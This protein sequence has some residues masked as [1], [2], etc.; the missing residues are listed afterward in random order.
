MTW[1]REDLA[2]KNIFYDEDIRPRAIPARLFP[3]HV[4]ALREAMLDFSFPALGYRVEEDAPAADQKRATDPALMPAD[5]I[6]SEANAISKGGYDE[7]RWEFFFK[8]LFFNPLKKSI[9]VSR[10]NSRR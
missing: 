8:E 7:K 10:E 4:E 5:H 9:S 3:S 1:D 6:Q 2:G